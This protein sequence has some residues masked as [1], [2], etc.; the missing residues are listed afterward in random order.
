M[1]SLSGQATAHRLSSPAPAVEVLGSEAEVLYCISRVLARGGLAESCL[2]SVV[3]ALRQLPGIQGAQFLWTVP[4]SLPTDFSLGNGAVR[5]VAPVKAGERVFGEVRI[6]FSL[7]E[8][9][10]LS[11]A[12][13][14]AFVGQQVGIWLSQR[15]LQ[16]KN[17]RLRRQLRETAEKLA[18]VK[19]VAR[20]VGLLAARHQVSA[21][22]AQTMLYSA[23][24]RSGRTVLQLAGAVI[25][26]DREGLVVTGAPLGRTA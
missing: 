6:F 9:G 5:A 4:T 15:L 11:P 17:D 16:E 10:T 2:A 12:R 14:A 8:L 3:L 22:L 21:K 18:H 23:A 19:V 25:E 26:A 24:E 20:A 1:P 7:Q 13:L